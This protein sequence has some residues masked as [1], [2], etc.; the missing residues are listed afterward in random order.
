MINSAK[1]GL[2]EA[3]TGKITPPLIFQGD[4]RAA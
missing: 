1:G 4:N 3:L 2:G